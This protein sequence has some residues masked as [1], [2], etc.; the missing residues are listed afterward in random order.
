MK[1]IYISVMISISLLSTPIMA[2]QPLQETKEIITSLPV[3][4][5]STSS[6]S[7][8]NGMGIKAMSP[9]STEIK[10]TP[11]ILPSTEI[12]TV[13]TTPLQ[14]IPA[15]ILN[16]EQNTRGFLDGFQ[17]GVGLG[18]LG[19]A[20]AHIGYRHPGSDRNFWKNR[21][22]FRVDYNS[23]EPIKGLLDDYLEDNPI[24][25]DGNEFTAVLEG[26]QLGAL[27]D[28]Y[29]FGN[30]WGLGNFRISGGYYSGDFKLG[31]NLHEKA[32]GRFDM[33]TDH[34]A[35]LYYE[36]EAI[37]DL[38]A[39]LDYDVTG[40]YAG[41]GADFGLFWGINLF[42]DAGVVFTDKPKLTTDITGTGKLK[43]YADSNYTSQTGETEID[44][45]APLIQKLLDDTKREYEHE[46]EEFMKGYFPMVKLGVLFRF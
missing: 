4:M 33:K 38:T 24:E 2:Q 19:G 6:S 1:N 13:S 11:T 26:E 45:N 25:V 40:P 32:G 12:K 18:V 23:W 37:A 3:E 20:N 28:F 10:I 9:P 7:I 5:I 21:F 14:K 43:I 42:F 44:S 41:I 15:N 17:L 29:P 16:A 22:G 35:T 8:P 31:G 27:I 39:T 34:G 46:L 36:V 30:T